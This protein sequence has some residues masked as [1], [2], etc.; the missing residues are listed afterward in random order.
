MEENEGGADGLGVVCVCVCV[1]MCVC[2]CVCVC[3]LNVEWLVS[4]RRQYLCKD[5]K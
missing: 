1:C 5:L 3:N 2:V 4:K